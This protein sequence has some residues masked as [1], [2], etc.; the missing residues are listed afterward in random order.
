MTA[1]QEGHPHSP[2]CSISCLEGLLSPAAYV[3]LTRNPGLK[4]INDVIM[5]KQNDE[6]GDIRNIGELRIREIRAALK[7]IEAPNYPTCI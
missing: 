2:E 4:T 7:P 5:L 1:R 6:L 3:S